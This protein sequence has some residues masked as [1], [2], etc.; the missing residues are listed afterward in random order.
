MGRGRAVL[1]SK[2]FVNFSYEKKEK[3]FSEFWPK[4]GNYCVSMKYHIFSKFPNFHKKLVKIGIPTSKVN[5]KTKKSE[6]HPLFWCHLGKRTTFSEIEYYMGN[7]EK[8]GG[9]DPLRKPTK[10][11]C[12]VP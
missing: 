7:A 6:N 10:H 9:P 5:K 2:F 8:M 11:N 3:N 4:I 12:L 1:A